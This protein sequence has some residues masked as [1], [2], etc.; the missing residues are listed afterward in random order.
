MTNPSRFSAFLTVYEAR[1]P[2][3][4][5]WP[6][7]WPSCSL[8]ILDLDGQSTEPFGADVTITLAEEKTVAVAA[9][10]KIGEVEEQA[11]VERLADRAETRH[12]PMIEAREMFV[13]E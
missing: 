11:H 13:L 4:T 1:K 3:A 10:M 2:A 9:V 5:S 8:M 7:C 6:M 12:Q